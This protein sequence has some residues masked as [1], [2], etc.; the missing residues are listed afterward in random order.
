MGNK[1]K[2]LS[3]FVGRGLSD[4]AIQD[5]HRFWKV[6]GVGPGNSIQR[7]H[8]PY[9]YAYCIYAIICEEYGIIG[10]L[11]VLW[12]YLW[13]LIRCINIVTK[14]RGPLGH[15]GHGTLSQPGGAGF[16]NISVSYSWCR[17]QG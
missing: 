10:G 8:L 9:A 2:D 16:A 13:L 4:S 15:T 5:C 3:Q 6:F 7:N 11:L 14:A 1:G 17:Q 12:L